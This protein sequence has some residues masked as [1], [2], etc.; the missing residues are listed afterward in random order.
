MQNLLLAASAITL[1]AVGVTGI[2][3]NLIGLKLRGSF[4]NLIRLVN[5]VKKSETPDLL[6]VL[7]ILG[8]MAVIF[9]YALA[10]GGFELVVIPAIAI[11]AVAIG[12]GADLNVG[13]AIL[14][15]SIANWIRHVRAL[16]IGINEKNNQP[17]PDKEITLP[18]RTI[19]STGQK[20]IFSWLPIAYV[21][22]LFLIAIRAVPS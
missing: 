14:L 7:K 2:L 21:W 1:A 12:Q 13:Y 22:Y 19:W 15:I 16:L 5:S 6:T 10:N 9:L 17:D 8:Y 11:V 20:V 4:E 18:P 3:A